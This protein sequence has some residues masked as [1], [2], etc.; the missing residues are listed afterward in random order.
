[1]RCGAVQGEPGRG[2]ADVGGSFVFRGKETGDEQD[3]S[4]ATSE[5]FCCGCWGVEVAVVDF[6]R[7]RRST[8]WLRRLTEEPT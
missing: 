8:L 6:S 5:L 3:V 7:Q 4:Q 2:H 1:M